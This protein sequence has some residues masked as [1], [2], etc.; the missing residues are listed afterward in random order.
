LA[1]GKPT[2]NWDIPTLAGAGAIR[3]TAA[4]MLKFAAANL[5][6]SDD[7]LGKAI[8]LAWT[9]HQKPLAP[10]EFAVGL[11]WHVAHDG[12]TRV[13][14]GQTGGYHAMLM[15][16]RRIKTAVVLLSNSGTSEI[17][18]LGEDLV[19]MLAGMNVEP[20]KFEQPV[21][22]SPQAMERYVGKYQ[23]APGAVFTVSV[24]DGKLTVGLTGQPEF[25]V[26]PRSDTEWFYKVV[27]AS[28]EFQLDEKGKCVALEITQ[29]GAKH[30]AERIE[31]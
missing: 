22:V 29:N 11:G 5:S 4:D 2:S 13:H 12:A 26:Y 1:G 23:L 7:E 28:I 3:G 9:V 14:S 24:D 15:V 31:E 18:R 25:Q 16:N 10:G 21:E 17:D 20:R 27:P 8:E 30:K 6:P 19:R